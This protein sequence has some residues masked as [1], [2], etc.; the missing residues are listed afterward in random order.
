MKKIGQQ[1]P[2]MILAIPAARSDAESE[3]VQRGLD[4]EPSG[5]SASSAPKASEIDPYDIAE[6]VYQMMRAE[7]RV[8]SARRGWTRLEG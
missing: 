6:R 7:L 5:A 3:N 1:P 4:T 2:E 8:E